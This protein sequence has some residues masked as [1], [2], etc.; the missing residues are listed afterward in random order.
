[1][2]IVFFSRTGQNA[3]HF[4]F[5]KNKLPANFFNLFFLSVSIEMTQ[6]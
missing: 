4:V 1:M 2:Y 5:C 6:Y 3:K